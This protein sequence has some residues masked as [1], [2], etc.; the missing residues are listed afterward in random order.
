MDPDNVLELDVRVDAAGREV[1][2]DGPAVVG[3]VVTVAVETGVVE[4][5]VSM[6]YEEKELGSREQ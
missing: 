1:V 3:V 6:E 5:D 2:V 4:I